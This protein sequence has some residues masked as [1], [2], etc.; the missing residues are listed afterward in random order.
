MKKNN[1]EVISLSTFDEADVI[2]YF[3]IKPILE[4]TEMYSK[5][6][7]KAAKVE[8]QKE[9]NAYLKT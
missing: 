3:G 8:L 5:W 2:Q 7:E 6:K 1:L 4:P 9:E